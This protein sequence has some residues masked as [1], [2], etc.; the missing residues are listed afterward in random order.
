[1]VMKGK[2]IVFEGADGSGKTTQ[3]KLLLK[4]LKSKKIPSAYI[5]FPRYK[6]SMWGEMVKRFLRGDFGGID[7][8][9]PYLASLLYAGDRMTASPTLKNWLKGGK[10]VV[11]NRYIGSNIGH[12]AAKIKSQSE[13]SKY[14]EWL[15]KLEYVENK[16]PKEDL[17][18]F[19]YVPVEISRRL[20]QERKLDIHEADL[21]YLEKVVDVYRDVAKSK[22][23][24]EAIDCCANGEILSPEEILKKVL[25]VLERRKILSESTSQFV[26]RLSSNDIVIDADEGIKVI[27]R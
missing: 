15:E 11:A 4:Y 12:M 9:D 8:V 17:V 25:E 7:Q 23:Y 2:L 13:R 27:K 26:L 22:N 24:W 10:I 3:S 21:G 1:M 16:I 18:I 19:L 20:I 5:S 6:D 14:I